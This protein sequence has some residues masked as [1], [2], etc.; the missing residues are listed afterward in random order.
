MESFQEM[1]SEA[2]F[3]VKGRKT[4]E[5]A[6][7][8]NSGSSQAQTIEKLSIVQGFLYPVLCVEWMQMVLTY[9]RRSFPKT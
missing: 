7:G 8:G 5:T 6:E 2:T 3:P 1:D 9:S 4:R